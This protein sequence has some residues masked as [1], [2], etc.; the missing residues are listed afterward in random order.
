MKER[1]NK[2][3]RHPFFSGSFVMIAGTTLANV[4][5]YLYHLVFG[6][7]LGPGGYGELAALLS[8]FTI[9][10]T[11]FSF[12]SLVVV[13]FV[14]SEDEGGIKR[15]YAW[16][17][18]KLFL[19]G[20]VI[21]VILLLLTP[22]F[23]RFLHLD[24]TLLLFI[25]FIVFFEIVVI[26][27]RAFLQGLLRFF[28]LVVVSNIELLSRLLFGVLLVAV[29][30]GVHGAAAGIMIGAVLAFFLGRKF[31]S[32][33]SGRKEDPGD[34]LKKRDLFYY[35]LP[36]FI[37]TLGINSL[38]TS[39]LLLVKHF[40][41]AETAGIYASLSTL[42]KVVYF[43]VS[44]ISSVMFPLVSNRFSRGKSYLPFFV[45]SVVAAIGIATFVIAFYYIFS[46]FAVSLLFGEK[47]LEA[48]GYLGKFGLF[49]GFLSLSYLF[50]SFFL[51]TDRKKI[52]FLTGVA[53]LAQIIGV[54]MFHANL[55]EVINV[56]LTAVSLF[57]ALLIIYFAYD[58]RKS[59]R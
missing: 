45:L 10:I 3:V 53:A 48:G 46:N 15:F 8:L 41:S 40:F 55:D 1:A 34:F 49:I 58:F 30:M 56:S 43:G 44:P 19:F 57:L 2:I 39:D 26:V 12:L 18:Q 17:K 27:V 22:L 16:I 24:F 21:L 31:L 23:E 20:L 59:R 50:V 5:A 14:S 6:R 9:V 47:F 13:K 54:V 7:L 28:Q 35:S 32:D 42:G 29:G 33:L 38:Y 51:C 52:A 37:F 11:L 36:T 4:V 25:P